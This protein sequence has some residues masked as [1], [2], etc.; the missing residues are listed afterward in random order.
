M[1]NFHLS[2][3]ME[4]NTYINTRILIVR[5]CVLNLHRFLVI[6]FPMREF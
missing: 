5:N 3:N 1:E 4:I 6:F 2:E